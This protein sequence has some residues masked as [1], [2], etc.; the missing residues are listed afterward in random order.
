MK[1]YFDESGKH[2]AAPVISIFGLLMSAGTC[3]GLQRR[4]LQEAARSPKIPLPF[5]MSDCVVGRKLFSYLENDEPARLAMQERMI[6]TL[7]GLDAQAH[8]I[9]LVRSDH[10]IVENDFEPEYRDPWFV[11]F[12]FGI[13]EMM[14]GS[15]ESGKAHNISI[16]FDRQDEF[17]DRAS[18]LYKKLLLNPPSY[19]ARL[20]S[21]TFSDRGKI[22]A[23][24]AADIVVYEATRYLAE[25]KLKGDP[26]R[27]QSKL[28][29]ETISVSGK[30]LDKKGLQL[31]KTKFA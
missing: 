9:A 21:L 31:L 10:A 6:G 14:L 28:L 18:D 4:W 22:A 26:E 29:R 24:Q 8:G 11:A 7:R 23:L 13:N 3:K 30:I 17:R 2:K 19:A 27:W 5:H 25:C 12:Q 20:G 1:A 15:A 16:V